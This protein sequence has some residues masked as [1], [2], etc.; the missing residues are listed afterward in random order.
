MLRLR[1]GRSARHPAVSIHVKLC[2]KEL[3]LQNSNT[4]FRCAPPGAPTKTFRSVFPQHL[5]AVDSGYRSTGIPRF[6]TSKSCL[7]C[8]KFHSESAFAASELMSRR[9]L[10]HRTALFGQVGQNRSEIP[11]ICSQVRAENSESGAV[12][13]VYRRQFAI[14]IELCRG[15]A[16]YYEPF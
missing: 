8:L 10:L 14:D 4:E 1:P 15:T 9:I 16:Q 3:A 5:P 7:S 12:V 6:S 2:Q 13:Q 11:P